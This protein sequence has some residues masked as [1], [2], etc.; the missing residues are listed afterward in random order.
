M[1]EY[2]LEDYREFAKHFNSQSFIN[3]IKILKDNSDI[4][5]LGSDYNWYNIQVK[6]KDIQEELHDTETG[7]HIK[8]EWGYRE[9]LEL[10]N[11][12]DISITDA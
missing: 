8:N 11:L 2:T 3:K 10:L 12:L 4:L 9:V 7:F 1:R 6:D 5:Q